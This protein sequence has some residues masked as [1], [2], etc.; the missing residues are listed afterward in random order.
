VAPASP[1]VALWALLLA[2][3][4]A[5]GAMAHGGYDLANALHPPVAA[6]ADLP[7]AADPRGLATFALSGLG[8]LV[9][10]ALLLRDARFPRAL[11]WLGLLSALLSIVLYL[12]RLVIL[13]P[14][15]PAIALPA[16]AEGFVVSPLWYL[17]LGVVLL[18]APND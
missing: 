4:G 14:A 8:L 11:A 10:A 2:G 15:S 12:G 6:N 17:W 16:L 7:S 13:S 5:L 1:P 3:F 18:R 9:F